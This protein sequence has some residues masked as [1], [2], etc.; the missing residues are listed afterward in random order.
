MDH[1][2][3][4]VWLMLVDFYA[5]GDTGA[6]HSAVG[7]PA[8][9]SQPSWRFSCSL[10]RSRGLVVWRCTGCR[11]AAGFMI[12]GTPVHLCLLVNRKSRAAEG[13]PSTLP[14]SVLVLKG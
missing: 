9:S 11:E 3:T 14:L 1:A 10:L 6:A 7:N 5:M 8:S 12:L 13:F 2:H 4:T